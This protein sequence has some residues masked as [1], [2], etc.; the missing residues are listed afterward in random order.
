MI[1]DLI[2]LFN[3]DDI[4]ILKKLEASVLVPLISSKGMIGILTLGERINLTPYTEKLLATSKALS[5]KLAVDIEN[6]KAFNFRYMLSKHIS[7]EVLSG[8]LQNSDGIK[9]GGERRKVAVLFA[10]IQQFAG[11]AGKINP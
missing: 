4:S 6:S 10:G 7:P 3:E 1:A 2:F 5:R 11:I 8:I 9:L